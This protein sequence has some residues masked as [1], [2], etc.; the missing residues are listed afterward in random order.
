MKNYKLGKDYFTYE[1]GFKIKLSRWQQLK[2]WWHIGRK[3]EPIK[4]DY[5]SDVIGE[6][7]KKWRWV[8]DE[9]IN[10]H[11]V[12]CGDCLPLLREEQNEVIKKNWSNIKTL[13]ILITFLLFACGDTTTNNITES[14]EPQLPT[15]SWS[16]AN[17][18]TYIRICTDSII[19][20]QQCSCM[21]NYLEARF[22][23]SDDFTEA[24]VSDEFGRKEIAEM[25][26][27]CV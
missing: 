20:F 27:E 5:C 2:Q 8:T 24:V 16:E 11:R 17:Q 25:V 12:C 4:C 10:F 15:N 14:K 9:R 6:N 21:L 22:Q 26:I 23:T 18:E 3:F 7:L 1:W 13:I 19:T